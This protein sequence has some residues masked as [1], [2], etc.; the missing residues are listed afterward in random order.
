MDMFILLI[1]IIGI[2]FLVKWI[3]KTN[4]DT[5]ELLIK[6]NEKRRQNYKEKEGLEYL[7]TEYGIKYLGGFK[8]LGKK[9]DDITLLLFKDRIRFEFTKDSYRDIM[10]KDILDFKIQNETQIRQ[11]ISMGKIILLGAFALAGNNTKE[12][13]KEFALL[14]CYYEGDRISIVLECRKQYYLEEC[15]KDIRKLIKNN[16]IKEEDFKEFFELKTVK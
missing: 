7:K 16:E 12:V 5:D 3:N 13:N 9:D 15:V 8:D 10:R 11:Q 1:V 2:I 6:I 14:D 4:K